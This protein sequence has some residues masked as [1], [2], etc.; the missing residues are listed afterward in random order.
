MNSYFSKNSP[1]KSTCIT[2]TSPNKSRKAC[3]TLMFTGVPTATLIMLSLK[4]KSSM[5]KKNSGKYKA[6]QESTVPSETPAGLITTLASV[7]IG[8]ILG[9]VLSETA[10]FI[11]M[12][13]PITRLDGSNKKI[14]KEQKSKGGEE[15]L[16]QTWQPRKT[17]KKHSNP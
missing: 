7:R 4:T 1:N 5:H 11:S 16:I 17:C 2:S 8:T 10:A 3:S 6:P 12:T 15:F 14:S 9:I 13:D